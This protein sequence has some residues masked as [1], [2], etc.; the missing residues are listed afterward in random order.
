MSDHTRDWAE[1]LY[2][3][4]GPG[5]VPSTEPVAIMMAEERANSVGANAALE[6]A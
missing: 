5:P 4:S 3:V 6:V 2:R 1:G